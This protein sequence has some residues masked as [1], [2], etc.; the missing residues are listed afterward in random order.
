MEQDQE[1][2]VTVLGEH[3]RRANGAVRKMSERGAA[4]EMR[5]RVA[6][7]TAIQL[8]S[9]GSLV[10]GQVVH[11]A[12]TGEGYLVGVDLDPVVCGL[13]ALNGRLQEFGPGCHEE[14]NV[15]RSRGDLNR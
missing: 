1:V 5:D 2:V 9:G 8:E 4:I 3:R 13:L 14:A 10:L 12:K 6:P 7:G 15:R 11:C